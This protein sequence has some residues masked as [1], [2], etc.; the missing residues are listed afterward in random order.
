[1]FDNSIVQTLETNDSNKCDMVSMAQSTNMVNS[2][3]ALYVFP[4]RKLRS[5]GS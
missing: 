2:E 1:M 3:D 5:S 4:S